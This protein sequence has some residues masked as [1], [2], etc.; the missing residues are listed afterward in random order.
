M[1]LYTLDTEHAVRK[2][3]FNEELGFVNLQAVAIVPA[4]SRDL[5]V[6]KAD[7]NFFKGVRKTRGLVVMFACAEFSSGCVSRGQ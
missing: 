5:D 7:V 1:A 2:H 4:L 3:P 6:L